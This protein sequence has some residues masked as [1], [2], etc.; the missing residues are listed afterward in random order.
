MAGY[1]TLLTTWTG[2]SMGPY[3]RQLPKY[4]GEVPVRDV[5]LIASEGRFTIPFENNTASG[6]LDITSHFFEFIPESEIDYAQPTVLG[7]HE[8]ELGQSYFLVPTTCAGLYRYQISDLVRVT[9]FLGR[10]PKVEFLGKGNRF[11]NLTGEKLSEHHVTQAMEKTGLSVAAY[12]LAP[13]WNDLCPYYG[14]FLEESDLNDDATSKRFLAEFDC[15]LCEKN[16]EYEA[17]RASGRIGPPQVAV[18][19]AG[20]WR[21]WDQKRLAKTGG[22]PEQYKRPCL[23]SDIAFAATMPVLRWIAPGG[24]GTN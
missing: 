22:S 9:D 3:L 14:I 2:G 7:A 5:G 21:T 11:A 18:L 6:V 8:L 24:H 12:T 15:A 4:Y 10:T 17:K 19:P 1:S 20:T 13:I 23:M 16:S